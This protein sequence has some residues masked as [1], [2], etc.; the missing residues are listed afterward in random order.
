MSGFIHIGQGASH[1]VV[2][3]YWQ[4]TSS[5]SGTI[6]P[7]ARATLKQDSF[8]DL[9]DALASQVM[10]DKPTFN[11]AVDATGMR[12]V[13]AMDV[14][15][16]FTL[17]PAPVSF[18]VAIVYRVVIPEDCLDYNSPHLMVEDIER[19]G[20]SGGIDSAQ[21]L[22]GGA[23]VY[24]TKSTD[25]LYFRTL[26]AGNGISVTEQTDTVQIQNTRTTADKVSD[27]FICDSSVAV[28]DLVVPSESA[29][30]EVEALTVNVY[31]NLCFGIVVAKPTSTTCEVLVSGKVSG[32]SGL[33]VGQPLFVGTDGKLSA[34]KPATGHIQTL[35][36]S[37][38]SSTAFFL[39]S[40]TK[41]VQS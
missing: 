12:V 31:S 1:N 35:G 11:A 24:K 21:N 27:L 28:G 18:P 30:G 32:L 19:P 10:D 16:N 23:G 40:L 8:Q 3:T 9:E 25:T 5:A 14:A 15:G 22:G 13:V 37:I 6:T 20:G 4:L 36:I 17:S 38:S 39:P 26:V 7:P 33:P 2:A 41:I 34:T 29:S